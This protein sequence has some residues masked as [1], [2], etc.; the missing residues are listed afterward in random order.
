MANGNN[1]T[2]DEHFVPRMHLR[3][4]SERKLKKS[5]PKDIIWA[6]NLATMKQF[7]DQ[8]PIEDIC[9]EEHLYEFKDSEGNF[10][11][12]N[13][14]EKALSNYEKVFSV[15]IDQILRNAKNDKNLHTR[16]FLSSK[17]KVFLTAFMTLQI[18]RYPSVL[19]IAEELLND[20]FPDRLKANEARN[21]AVWSCLDAFIDGKFDVEKE[22][23]FWR[24]ASWFD[25]MAFIIGRSNK[26]VF[27][28]SDRPIF[29]FHS[30][31]DTIN[32][33]MERPEK[34]IFPLS[35]TIA[36]YM[37]PNCKKTRQNR[38]ILKDLSDKSIQEIQWSIAHCAKEW[39]YSRYPISS[40]QLQIIKNAKKTDVQEGLHG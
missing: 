22:S 32:F 18:L 19:S 38:N 8:I 28:T 6:Y 16:C 23:I 4:F 21:I 17:E 37:I 39:I 26:P 34:I 25:D 12:R 11:D 15:V 29:L 1:P 9:F 7:P 31:C 27:F 40:E 33:I 30:K 24:I 10:I 35:P 20:M 2:T 3:R 14:V 5:K 36:L 13:R